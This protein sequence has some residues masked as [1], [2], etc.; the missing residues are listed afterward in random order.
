MLLDEIAAKEWQQ[1]NKDVDAMKAV[2]AVTDCR[3]FVSTPAGTSGVYY[4]IMHQPSSMLK[5]VMDWRDNPTKNRGLYQ[6]KDGVPVAIDPVN[7]PL[8][9]NYSPPDEEI[10]T[11]FSQ[12]RAKGFRLEGKTR[13]PWYDYECN[14]AAA[15]PQS[16]AQEQDRDYGG[17]DVSYLRC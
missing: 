6:F 3:V 8:P 17:R 7:N 11:L 1:G 5:I 13:S 10:L 12:L 14:R 2:Q 16:I 9:S 4:E 15:T